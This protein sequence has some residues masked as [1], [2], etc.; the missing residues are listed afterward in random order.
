VIKQIFICAQ[1]GLEE[2]EKRDPNVLGALQTGL[3]LRF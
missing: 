2:D 3:H 1:E